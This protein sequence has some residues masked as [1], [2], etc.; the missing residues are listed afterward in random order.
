MQTAL[1][2]AAILIAVSS[3]QAQWPQW[4]GP[5]RDGTVPAA[6]VPAAWPAAITSRWRQTV[7]EGY[8]SPVIE[9]GRVFVHSRQGEDEV[10]SAFRAADGTPAWSARYRSAFV[11]NKYAAN[12]ANGP[13]S[14]PLIANGVLY[15]LGAR[16]VLTAWDAQTGAVRWRHDWSSSVDTSK[17]FTGTAMSPILDS[18]LLIVHTGDDGGGLFRALDPM[19]GAEKW[20]LP[21]HGPGYASPIVATFGGV[22]QIVTMTDKAVIGVAV[23]DGR[24][25]WQIPFPDE[26]NENIVTPVVAGDVLI[27]SGTRKGT[28]GYRVAKSSEAFNATQVWHNTDLPMYMSS[29]V[30]DGRHVYGFSS[31][32][33][34]QLFCADAATGTARWTTEGR[35][36]G[37]ASIQQAGDALLVLTAEGELLVLRRNPDKYEELRR[38]KVGEQT[39]AQPVLLGD[40]LIVRDGNALIGLSLTS[41]GG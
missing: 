5:A 10:V 24:A 33:K 8:S 17:L 37:N 41:T 13:F 36:G 31:R 2:A 38:Y 34:G 12:M 20:T 14:T 30:V 18:G 28:F 32:R 16:A 11:K 9:Q 26:W 29:P 19:T 35:G 3:V 40:L 1:V 7:G 23:G 22:R 25:L 21:G 27:V 4:R 6:S 15:T 39:W